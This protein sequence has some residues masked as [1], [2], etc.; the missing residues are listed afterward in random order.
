M[1]RII[2]AINNPILNEKLCN[3]KNIEVVGKDI[4]YKDAILEI[5]EEDSN[6]DLLIISDSLPGET[7]L[8][9][10]TK[11]IKIYNIKV[12]F[13]LEKPNRELEEKLKKEEIYSIYY[14]NKITIDEIIKVIK[15]EDK[16]NQEDIKKELE[17]L[18]EIVLKRNEKS[19]EKQVNIK[20]KKLFKNIIKIIKKTDKKRQKIITFFGEYCVGKTS[21]IAV[22][23]KINIKKIKKILIINFNEKNNDIFFIFSKEK[24]RNFTNQES[25]N[26]ISKEEMNIEKVCKK[27]SILDGKFLIKNDNFE[28]TKFKNIIKKYDLVYIENSIHNNKKYNEEILKLSDK[29]LCVCEPNIINISKTKIILEK[30][31]NNYFINEEKINILFNKYNKY[32][33]EENLLKKIFFNF[34][35][36]GKIKSNNKNNYLINTKYKKVPNKIKKEYKKILEKIIFN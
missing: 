22:F 10:L 11:K 36:I 26:F 3:E 12:I 4:Q 21:I 9:M 19:I 8:I 16:K 17:E 1:K 18:K 25:Q 6:I 20:H 27:I 31:I 32:S 24:N 23:A 14:N 15:N 34:N 7:D 28:E 30:Y 13:I 29:L 5:L 2:T 35:V 33:I